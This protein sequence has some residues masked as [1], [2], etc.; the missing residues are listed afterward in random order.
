[1]QN[2][3]SKSGTSLSNTYRLNCDKSMT[4]MSEVDSGCAYCDN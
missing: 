3:A 2:F 1:M 4:T